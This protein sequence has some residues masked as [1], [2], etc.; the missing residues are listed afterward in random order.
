MLSTT[1]KD[2][3]NTKKAYEQPRRTQREVKLAN[4]KFLEML[5]KIMQA[6]KNDI[7]KKKKR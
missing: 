5:Q 7:D 2:A 1:N 4:Q 6:T 3:E